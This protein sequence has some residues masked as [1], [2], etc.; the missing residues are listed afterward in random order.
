MNEPLDL[1]VR[2]LFAFLAV[3]LCLLSLVD[4]VFPQLQMYLLGGQLLVG[5]AAIKGVLLATAAFGCL[6]P[7]RAR[8]ELPILTWL[9]CIGFLIAEILYLTSSCGMSLLNVLQSYNGYY[10]LLLIGPALLTFR[11]AVPER[12]II[13]YTVF[14]LL[15]CAVI[16][17]AQYL[18]AKPI[19]YTRSSDGSFS[20][21]SWQFWGQVRAFSLFSSALEFGIFCTF[22]GALGIALSRTRPMKGW[23]LVALSGT[24]CFATLTRL[25]YLLFICACSYAWIL[26]FGRKP[27]RGLWQPLLYFVLGIATLLAGLA[28]FVSGE[29]AALQDPSSL[30]DRVVQWAYYY[31]LLAHATLAER[32]FGFGIVQNDKVLPLFP[33]VIDNLPLALVL[34]IGAVGLLLFGILLV[35]MWLYLRRKAL[36]TQEPMIVAAASLWATLT[37]A[38]IFSITFSSFGAV[39]AIAI[40]CE[41]NPSITQRQMTRTKTPENRDEILRRSMLGTLNNL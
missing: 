41:R 30:I 23:L 35:K 4:G 9:L 38:G 15:V 16:G 13:R 32:L 5:N 39:F 27:A 28:S 21:Q 14:L 7:M 25:C 40:L 19:L 8:L 36:A 34:H 2:R 6:I 37:C 22:C 17:V 33:M 18:L 31:D 26:T 12:V 29:A 1:S 24:A 3:T 20:V 10:P 11:G